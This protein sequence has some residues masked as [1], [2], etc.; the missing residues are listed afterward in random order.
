MLTQ[1]VDQFECAEGIEPG[2]HLPCKLIQVF[3][4]PERMVK[5]VFRSEFLQA[6]E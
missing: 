4:L 3:A 2:V 5:R 1:E 6:S